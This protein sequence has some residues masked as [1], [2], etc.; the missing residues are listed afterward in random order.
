MAQETKNKRRF[1]APVLPPLEAASAPAG[2]VAGPNAQDEVAPDVPS[3]AKK[4]FAVFDPADAFDYPEGD[5]SEGDTAGAEPIGKASPKFPEIGDF[6][7]PVHE[8]IDLRAPE[9]AASRAQAA[10][11]SRKVLFQELNAEPNPLELLPPRALE[12][13]PGGPKL[14][15]TVTPGNPGF[16]LFVVD[17]PAAIRGAMA[18]RGSQLSIRVD[19]SVGLMHQQPL[20]AVIQLP[21]NTHVQLHSWVESMAPDVTVLIGSLDATNFAEIRR[22]LA[23]VGQPISRGTRPR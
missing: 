10:E 1:I 19:P 5:A 15:P 18:L 23:G 11:R 16:A 20:I 22:L 14:I 3:K 21:N 9:P 6:G 12:H 7:G 4:S 8:A 2:W 13:L 17:S